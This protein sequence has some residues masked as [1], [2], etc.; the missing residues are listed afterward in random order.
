MLCALTKPVC[1]AATD[2][3]VKDPVKVLTNFILLSV[4]SL[5]CAGKIAEEKA[6][7]RKEM[8]AAILKIRMPARLL[9]EINRHPHHLRALH[10]HRG[11][12]HDR[13]VL[14][15]V[16]VPRAHHL[17]H[18]HLLASALLLALESLKLVVLRRQLVL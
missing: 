1:E 17:H 16:R 3:G 7:T 4:N 5:A 8:P 11:H 15:V 10:I 2:F 18:H 13:D 12:R 9:L 6:S 14:R